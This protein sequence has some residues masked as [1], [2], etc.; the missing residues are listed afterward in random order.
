MLCNFC[1]KLLYDPP[2]PRGKVEHHTSLATFH[3]AIEAG[4]TLCCR[5]DTLALGHNAKFPI[6]CLWSSSRDDYISLAFD[7]VRVERNAVTH[8][9]NRPNEHSANMLLRM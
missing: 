1:S 3:Q 9:L 6:I 2:I 7:L 4:C 8:L 5:L